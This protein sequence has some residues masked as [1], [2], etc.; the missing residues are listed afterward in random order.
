MKRNIFKTILAI[1]GLLHVLFFFI[2]PFATINAAISEMSDLASALGLNTD[3]PE[4][5]TGR[6][7][8]SFVN[9]ADYAG[10][11]R[12]A[13]IVAVTAPLVIGLII[14]LLNLALKGRKS[15]VLSLILTIIQIFPYLLVSAL[16]SELQGYYYETSSASFGLIVILI[17]V[18]FVV[19]ILAI[20][21]GGSKRK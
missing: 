7:I 16:C 6:G 10:A 5:L 9:I 13:F 14:A 11:Q 1:A 15:S 3:L 20:A 21:T 12:V 2:L 19:A 18:Q 17:L 4:K 8:L